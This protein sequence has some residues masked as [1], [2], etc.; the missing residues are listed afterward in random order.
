MKTIDLA[1]SGSGTRLGAH[2]GALK[3]LL[4]SG[5]KPT[6]VAAT[7]GGSIIAALYCTGMAIDDLWNVF[8][9]LDLN[10]IRAWKPWLFNKT[11]GIWSVK[12]LG[13]FLTEKSGGATFKNAKIELNIIT[14]DYAMN[15]PLVLNRDNFPDM[16]VGLAAM[17]SASQPFYFGYHEF[18]DLTGRFYRLVDGG[19]TWNYPIDYWE[20]EKPTDNLVGIKIKGLMGPP[21]S[22]EEIKDFPIKKYAKLTMDAW[23]QLVDEQHV[24]NA[25]WAKTL[26]IRVPYRSLDFDLTKVQRLDLL[27]IGYEQAKGLIAEKLH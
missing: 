5:C 26:E 8:A 10:T 6:R 21:P 11:G 4:E 27:T 16:P 2:V 22:M 24:K 13:K 20:K 17:Y 18:T 15:R 19:L 7:S 25:F 9:D 3:A 23:M 1:L 12:K 14:H